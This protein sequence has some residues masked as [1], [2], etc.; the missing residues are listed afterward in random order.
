MWRSE[1][2]VLA[3]NVMY[4]FQKLTNVCPILARIVPL[5][6]NLS[7]ATHA[8]ALMATLEHFAIQVRLSFLTFLAGFFK[9]LDLY[10]GLLKYYVPYWGSFFLLYTVVDFCA[11]DPCLNG[12]TCRNEPSGH[13][14]SCPVGFVQPDCD[15]GTER[16]RRWS[17]NECFWLQNLEPERFWRSCFST[18]ISVQCAI[19][20]I[21]NGLIECA[22]NAYAVYTETC[23][24]T[25]SPGFETATST[26]PTCNELGELSPIQNC[27]GMW[28]YRAPLMTSVP[29]PDWIIF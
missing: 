8:F 23:D 2:H 24:V 9:T 26:P 18:H 4:W 10:Y 28:I 6:T 12:G 19:P 7:T 15:P 14:C 25:C 11:L 5:A 13:T 16:T 20:S 29:V 27:D 3:W 1:I 22:S 21:T 17:G